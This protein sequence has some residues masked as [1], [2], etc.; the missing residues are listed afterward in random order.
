MKNTTVVPT[1]K[2]KKRSVTALNSWRKRKV[3]GLI[4]SRIEP[5]TKNLHPNQTIP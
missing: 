4:K 1:R 2:K 3:S 5:F